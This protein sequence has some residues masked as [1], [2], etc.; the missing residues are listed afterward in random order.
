MAAPEVVS[1]PCV[2]MPIR[3]LLAVLRHSQMFASVTTGQ[4]KLPARSRN[5]RGAD[6]IRARGSPALVRSGVYANFNLLPESGRSRTEN[7]P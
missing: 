1:N 5:P 4:H 7:D 2:S 3:P 6:R